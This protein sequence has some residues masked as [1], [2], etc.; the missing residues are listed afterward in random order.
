MKRFLLLG[1]TS[2]F[3]RSGAVLAG[4]E[5][6]VIGHPALPKTDRLTVQRIYT[7]R[8]VL[9]GEQAVVPVN[10]PP[11]NPVRDEFLFNYLGQKEEQY[12]GYWLVRRYVGKGTPP[13]ELGGVDELIKYVQSTPGALGYVPAARLP[14][15]A[16]VIV[17]R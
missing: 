17:G 10:L 4:E 14:R 1:L 9:L 6:V 12:T 16:N 13:L 5:V 3:L 7:G 2:L 15:G 8:V 11:G